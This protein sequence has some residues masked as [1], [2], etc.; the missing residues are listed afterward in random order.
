VDPRDKRLKEE[1]FPS[2]QKYLYFR[3]IAL[4]EPEKNGL[5][6]EKNG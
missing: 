4:R 2:S 5:Y 1:A 6:E 3:P